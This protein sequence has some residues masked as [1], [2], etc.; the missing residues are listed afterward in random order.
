MQD[1]TVHRS[2]KIVV[3]SI[4]TPMIMVGIADPYQL[5]SDHALLDGGGLRGGID[6]PKQSGEFQ[7]SASKTNPCWDLIR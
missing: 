2:I 3:V 5:D 4:S 1:V 6:T 7:V